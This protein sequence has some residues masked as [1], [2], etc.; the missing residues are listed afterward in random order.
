[1][2]KFSDLAALLA[3]VDGP[4]GAAGPIALNGAFRPMD[5]PPHAWFEAVH[6]PEYYRAF[7]AGTLDEKATRRYMSHACLAS[8]RSRT[9]WC[10]RPIP[11]S[12]GVD[13]AVSVPGLKHQVSVPECPE[14]TAGVRSFSFAGQHLGV[15]S[16][17]WVSID[18]SQPDKTSVYCF[19]RIGL[20]YSKS[21][22]DR[23]LLEVSG[24][25][26]AARLAL[27]YGLACNLAGGTHHAHRDFGSG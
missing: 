18:S 8:G 14:S 13:S 20:P 5:R 21:L 27:K 23:T 15:I 12:A 9:I 2:S 1:M 19:V 4:L 6:D 10:L 22:V 24:T 11:I 17:V 25:V 7:L 3:K 26:L 16:H